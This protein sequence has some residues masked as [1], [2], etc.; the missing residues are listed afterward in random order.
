MR[1][2]IDQHVTCIR[3]FIASF[4]MV[5]V[6]SIVKKLKFDPSF[7][8]NSI[9]RSLIRY[10]TFTSYIHENLYNLIEL[11]SNAPLPRYLYSI[12]SSASISLPFLAS[13]FSFWLNNGGDS[14]SGNNWDAMSGKIRWPVQIATISSWGCKLNEKI[15]SN[16]FLKIKIAN[17]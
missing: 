17:F 13:L 15:L 8:W 11:S 16:I 14:L 2:P 5:K 6:R 10:K 12:K 1:N 4:I 7:G 3:P 9:F